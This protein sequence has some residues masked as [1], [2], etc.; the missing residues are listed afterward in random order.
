MLPKISEAAGLK[1]L[2]SQFN[3]P[4]NMEVTALEEHWQIFAAIANSAQ[5]DVSWSCEV[6]FFTHKWFIQ[7]GN[8]VWHSF[9]EEIYKQAW[10]QAQF[11]MSKL[12]IDLNWQ[13]FADAIAT[14]RLKPPPYIVDQVKH[15]LA[16][17][18]GVYPAFRP[19]INED[20]API[21]CIQAAFVDIYNLRKYIPT[22][23]HIVEINARSAVPVYYS[24]YNATLLAGTPKKKIFSTIMLDLRDIKLLLDTIKD[25][26]KT[27]I[28]FEYFHVENDIYNEIQPSTMICDDDPNFLTGLNNFPDREFCSTS[29]FWRGCIRITT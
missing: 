7:K 24:L 11:A 6:L 13:C 16:I 21:K 22:I 17:A 19:A 14:R 29:P 3:L 10:T 18:A 5:S 8:Q 26:T 1:K 27:Q 2:R 28:D 23:M 12:V 4:Y 15:L 9:Y 20:A 25:T